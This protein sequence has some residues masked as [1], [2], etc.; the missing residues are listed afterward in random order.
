MDFFVLCHLSMLTSFGAVTGECVSSV[1]LAHFKIL[2][3]EPFPMMHWFWNYRM[4]SLIPTELAAWL[5]KASSKTLFCP[6]DASVV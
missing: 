4:T 6:L 3:V 5:R 2:I 1:L